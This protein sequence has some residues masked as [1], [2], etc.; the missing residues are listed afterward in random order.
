MKKFHWG[1]GIALFFTLF[2]VATLYMVV[3]A[4]KQSIELK[5]E[6]YYEEEIQYQQRITAIQNAKSIN[7][8]VEKIIDDSGTYLLLPSYMDSLY[9]GAQINF[10]RPS[11]ESYDFKMD[12]DTDE[13]GLFKV[14]MEQI[15]SG[16][17][18]LEISFED[19][20]KSYYY[21]TQVFF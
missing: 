3:K 19:S 7:F 2:V 14:P 20:V 16:L 21:E 9:Q 10:Y 1:H 11:N 12:L 17:Y 4:G 13:E 6:N 15:H 5:T 8:F 18:H